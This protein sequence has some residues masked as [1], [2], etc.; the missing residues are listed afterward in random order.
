LPDTSPLSEDEKRDAF[1]NAIMT[2]VPQ[3]QSV[4]F[5]TKNTTNKSLNNLNNMSYGQKPVKSRRG[6]T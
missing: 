6:Q 2:A 1:Y 4:E 5:M 3:V